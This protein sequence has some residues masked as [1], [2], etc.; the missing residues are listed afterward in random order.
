MYMEE[1]YNTLAA[2]RI[3]DPTPGSDDMIHLIHPILQAYL[4]IKSIDLPSCPIERKLQIRT[5]AAVE[6]LS[7]K[8]VE[9]LRA[10]DGSSLFLYWPRISALYTSGYGERV[11][12]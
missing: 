9:Q 5:L 4:T 2:F 12:S 6:A 8:T 11:L 1:I 3:A 10:E 7:S